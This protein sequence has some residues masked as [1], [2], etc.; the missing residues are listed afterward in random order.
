MINYDI[1]KFQDISGIELCENQIRKYQKAEDRAIHFLENEL[2][3]V[4][5]YETEYV[6]KGQTKNP[7]LCPKTLKRLDETTLLPPDEVQGKVKLFPYDKKMSTIPIDP[8]INIY[9]L[10]LVVPMT[11]NA[12][13]YI[14]VKK[15][16]NIMPTA[17]TSFA[18]FITS[19]ERCP[20]WPN[21]CGCE[22][23]NCMMLAVDAD[24]LE[25]LPG[26][27][28]DILTEMILYF[29]RH[30]FSLESQATIK[31]ESVDGHSVS[32]DTTDDLEKILKSQHY[33]NFINA[34]MGPYSPYYKKVRLY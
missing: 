22:C 25:E 32:Y 7:C 31:S 20:G 21:I 17:S 4:F 23:N 18:N 8:A 5:D 3:W 29:M 11:G 30:P 14:T 2:G 27:M 16:E 19:V 26:Y 24:W 15:L 28:L 12:K 6:E 33:I 10:K 9:S 1:A 13:E 34:Y